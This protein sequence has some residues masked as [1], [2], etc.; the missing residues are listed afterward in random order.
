MSAAVAH[1]DLEA[2]GS[3]IRALAA[4][5]PQSKFMLA[6][7]SNAYGHGLHEVVRT[8]L[9]SGV[10]SFGVL[11]ANAGI[12]LRESGVEVPLFAWMHGQGTDFA[13]A[14]EARVDLG[15]QTFWQLEAIAASGARVRPR[16]HLKID[17]GLHRGGADRP[18]WAEFVTEALRLQAL[19]KL[20]VVAAWS[21]LSDTSHSADLESTEVF[22]A[23][24]EEARALGADFELLHL[25]ASAAVID[26]PQ[27]HFDLVRVGIAAYGISPFGDRSAAD[28]GLR[29]AM[30][31]RAPV[32]DAR[33]GLAS[34]AVGY[35]DGI[36]SDPE[37]GA[38]VIV[39]GH[40]APVV[41]VGVDETVVALP[42][43]AAAVAAGGECIVFGDGSNGEATAEQW[44]IWGET[45]GDEIVTGLTRR[46]ARSFGVS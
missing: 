27:A 18:R 44:A 7:K 40:I 2:I 23:A 12:E 43:G 24:V 3:N 37:G 6:V 16:V 29:P 15:V 45:V 13:A 8:G 38:Y 4:L 41:E 36:Q 32:L 25:G 21:H 14:A 9:D 22:I 1:V 39:D 10:D 17:T 19:G 28:L 31:L 35:G 11:E 33:H 20:D 34:I 46:V 5:A 26:L 30:Q 42:Q